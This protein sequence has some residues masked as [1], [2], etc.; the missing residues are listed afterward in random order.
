MTSKNT[1][2]SGWRCRHPDALG[3]ARRRPPL[4]AAAAVRSVRSGVGA[5]AAVAIPAAAAAPHGPRRG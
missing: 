2:W 3:Q 4:G 5:A 1:S